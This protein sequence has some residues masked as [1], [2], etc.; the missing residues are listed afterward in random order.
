M[1]RAGIGLIS[2]VA[3]LI[4]SNPA[5]A[6]CQANDITGIHFTGA[7]LLSYNPFTPYA[8]QTV[9]ITINASV[10]CSVEL[11]FLSASLPARMTGPGFLTYDITTSSGSTSLVY[12]PGS[13]S[14]T[15]RVDVGSGNPGSTAVQVS[16]PPGQ[17]V[18]DGI[19]ADPT[20]LAQ[21]FDKTG[22]TLILLKSFAVPLQGQVARACHFTAPIS[23]T[24]NFTSAIQHG[25]P[26]PD[27]V[28]SVTFQDLSCTAPSI[29]RLTA[30]AMQLMPTPPASP[31]FDSAINVRARATFGAANAD[32]NTGLGST[33]AS[34][35]RHVMSGA[36]TGGSVR[37]DVNLLRGRPLLP[38]TYTTTLTLSIDPSL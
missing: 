11:A 15:T 29:V 30:T 24:M 3:L 4:G 33:V 31:S 35:S 38:G 34:M 2:V 27:V 13:P 8:P 21:V 36:T 25:L 32:L 20:L 37:L 10:A 22:G 18:S 26:N 9:A 17:V 16:I 1:R 23:T 14:A 7:T 28:Q 19:Y 12:P 6:A 5:A